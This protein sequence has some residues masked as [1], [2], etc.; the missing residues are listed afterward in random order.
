MAIRLED[1]HVTTEGGAEIR[2]AD[3]R[4]WED[5]YASGRLP[6]GYMTEGHSHAGRPKLYEE[7]MSTMTIRVPKSEKERLTRE[8]KRRGVSLSSYVREVIATNS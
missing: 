6:N 7:E 3:V 8:A 4:A 1:L 5:A 2:G